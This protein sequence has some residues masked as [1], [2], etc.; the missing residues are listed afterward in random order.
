MLSSDWTG[1][2]I[3]VVLGA[4][5]PFVLF[6]DPMFSNFSKEGL[7]AVIIFGLAGPPILADLNKCIPSKGSGIAEKVGRYV[8]AIFLISAFGVTTG[9]VGLSYYFT[10]GAPKAALMPICFFGAAGLGFM[11]A[12][13]VNPKL[14]YRA[15]SRT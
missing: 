12:Y 5:Q 6:D 4:V 14:A 9:I 3:G 11:L 2:A 10:I 13:I 1:I 7:V 8:N 15:E